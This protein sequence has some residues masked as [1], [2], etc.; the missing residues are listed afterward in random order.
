MSLFLEMIRAHL[1]KDDNKNEDI[2]ILGEGATQG[3]D[4]S[5]INSI[6]YSILLPLHNQTKDM[7]KVCAI[8]EA[9]VSYL[10]ILQKYINSKQKT[11][12]IKDYEFR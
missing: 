9:T 12:K 7:Y 5:L 1:C 8:M 3:L 6:S 2:L 4:D 11:L 10:L